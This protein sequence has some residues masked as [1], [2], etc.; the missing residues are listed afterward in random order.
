MNDNPIVDREEGEENVRGSSQVY[1]FSSDLSI[2]PVTDSDP[3][4]ES[5][6]LPKSIAEEVSKS[7]STI[8]KPKP[9]I[10]PTRPMTPPAPAAHAPAAQ[11]PKPAQ[12]VVAPQQQSAPKPP[13][14][15]S[16]PPVA[17]AT[18][19]NPFKPAV[20]SDPFREPV[21]MSSSWPFASKETLEKTRATVAEEAAK[22]PNTAPVRSSTA[23]QPPISPIKPS[24][25]S[26]LITSPVNPTQRPVAPRPATP[27]PTPATAAPTPAAAP[28]AST[29]PLKPQPISINAAGLVVAPPKPAAPGASTVPGMSVPGQPHSSVLKNIRTYEG[30]VA[31]VLAQRGTS[32]VSMALAESKKRGEG[33]TLRNSD[34]PQTPPP[35]PVQQMQ[36]P[37]PQAQPPRPAQARP[38]FQ[39]PTPFRQAPP[40]GALADARFRMTTQAPLPTAPT[41]RP[42]V[43]LPPMPGSMPA[44][45]TQPHPVMASFQPGMEAPV[46]A[47]TGPDMAHVPPVAPHVVNIAP[48]PEPPS[49]ALS[50]LV[51][52]VLSLILIFG[53]AYAGYYFYSTSPVAQIN[54]APKNSS[55]TPIR[56]VTALVPFDTQSVIN[57][58]GLNF[59]TLLAKITEEVAKPMTP[60]ATIREVVL[61]ETKEGKAYRVSA[62]EIAVM[63]GVDVPDIILRTLNPQW[64]FGVYST[65]DNVRSAF[66]VV[67]T[68]LFQNAF[69]GMLSWEP[70]L[71]L[72]IRKLTDADVRATMS[73]P[74]GVF[75]DQI[76]KNKDVRAFVSDTGR[77]LFVYS[78]V[79]NSTLVIAE[80]GVVLAEIIDRLDN[81]AYVR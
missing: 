17:T 53:G 50:K 10:V 76:V 81:K 43:P 15:Q 70:A 4:Y 30:D 18:P 6:H 8:Q 24:V 48:L 49:H 11:A 45:Q 7:L 75:K 5:G 28:A 68:N 25:A 3:R 41:P 37:R 31:E 67:N 1:D 36:Q 72:E 29:Q 63:L 20:P 32:R 66:V 38:Q 65:P 12:P 64:M 78:F 58:D 39:P 34:Q 27:L 54:N 19:V 44:Q 59:D 13:M 77:T 61:T 52:V 71:P 56:S 40:E 23:P 55:T 47:Y 16:T 73:A 14:P 69:A 42:T 46:H 74:K 33:E 21:E 57:T 62:P 26:T 80:N 51:M 9:P 22:N 2:S 60:G 35:Q 79:D